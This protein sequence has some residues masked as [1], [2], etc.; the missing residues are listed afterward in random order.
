MRI[1][2]TLFVLVLVGAMLLV[3]P[4]AMAAITVTSIL[5]SSG[6][7]G[8]TVQ[9]TVTGTFYAPVNLITPHAPIFELVNGATT[10]TGTTDSASVKSTS[11]NVSFALPAAAPAV[12]YALEAHQ[13][14]GIFPGI[15]TD[16]S[17]L[18]HAFQVVPTISSLSPSS[19]VAG[20]GELTLTV[21]GGGFVDWH[22]P[23]QGSSVRWN[24]AAVATTFNSATKLTAIIPASRLTTAG[25][26]EVTVM[27][28]SAGT[29]SAPATFT[30][31]ALA[32]FLSS[33]TP[34]SV[35]A[36]Y[37]KNDVVL[38]VNG[39]NFLTGAHIFLRGGE[40]AGTTF[41]N[42]SQLTVPLMAADIS[43]PTTLTVSV[44]N[45]PFPPG[46][47]SAG[48]L[49]LPVVAET[50]DPVVTIGGADSAWHK[51][52]VAL[53]FSA[54]D[55]QSG[56]QN[57]QYQSPP[58]VAAWTDGAAYTV[59]VT[60]QGAITVSAQALDWCNRVGTASAT[61]NIDTTKPGTAA[62][63]TVS[64]KKGKTAK[65]KY[66]V[67][68][69]AGLSPSAKV[70]ILINRRNGTTAKTIT[71]D[72]APTN[73]QRTYSFRCNLARGSYKWYVYATDLAGNAQDNVAKATLTVK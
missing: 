42:A 28:E 17:S 44:K 59:P 19:V 22:L 62:L 7:A 71:I 47:S 45:P 36:G 1:R 8:V 55:S 30:I 24:G 41:V 63:G 11:A 61:V 46:T 29:T 27:N 50:T 16:N 52:P 23:Y 66:R 18:A 5:P 73:S 68:E 4:A 43:T 64:V 70:V 20:A 57:V 25:N 13:T 9:C 53:T 15:T 49:L 67:T 33:L 39:G 51:T 21:N 60:T 12:W 10:I 38:T 72:S 2:M 14:H 32:P 6:Q 58:T 37:V 35:W 65:L 54:T 31:T 56:V 48:A 40:K 3:A 69:P 26:A 34:T